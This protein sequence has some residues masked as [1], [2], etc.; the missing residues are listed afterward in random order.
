MNASSVR[1]FQYVIDDLTQLNS[2]VVRVF[3]DT[4]DDSEKFDADKV[5]S[6]VNDFH[7]H[8]FLR[9]GLKQRFWRKVG[10][11]TVPDE[12]DVIFRDTNDYGNPKIHTSKNWHIWRANGPFKIIG[13]LTPCYDKAEIGVVVPPGSLIHRLHTGSYDFV[14]PKN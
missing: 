14:Y 2:Q 6:G 7:A 13:E 10:H 11:A 8:V 5:L 9:L 1:H 12:V 4:F 3:G